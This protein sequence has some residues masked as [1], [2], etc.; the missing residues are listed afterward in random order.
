MLTLLTIVHLLLALSLITFVLL[1]DSKGGGAFGIGGGS[2]TQGVFGASG[3]GNFLVTATKWIAT[4]FAV[5]C[6]ALSY[7]TL[8]KT[9]SVT[10]GYIPAAGTT[11]VESAPAETA[12]T[13]AAPDAVAPDESTQESE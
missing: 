11:A 2:G 12:P 1:Q 5:T 13:E 3:A 10:D 9:D 4:L 8:S 7:M 6:I